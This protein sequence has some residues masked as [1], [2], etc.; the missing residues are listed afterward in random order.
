MRSN[1][2]ISDSALVSTSN[3]ANPSDFP[4]SF[5]ASTTNIAEK[6][7]DILHNPQENS[8]TRKDKTHRVTSLR[9]EGRSIEWARC[10]PDLHREAS[11]ELH[12]LL[13]TPSKSR[14]QV[15]RKHPLG[16]DHNYACPVPPTQPS[17]SFKSAN[18]ENRAQ[19][20]N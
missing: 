3:S 17:Y 20:Q 6:D 2:V 19:I 8:T 15:Y 4:T 10:L 14:E 18:A 9:V 13:V 7:T 1:E 12:K 16:G 5:P 11:R